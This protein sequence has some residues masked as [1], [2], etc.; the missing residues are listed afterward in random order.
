MRLPS[1]RLRSAVLVATALLPLFVAAHT[2]TDVRIPVQVQVASTPAAQIRQCEQAR[3]GLDGLGS[4]G[5]KLQGAL[6]VIANLDV[7]RRVWPKATAAIVEAAHLQADVA[8]EFNLPRNAVD[9]LAAALPAAKATTH[10]AWLEYRLGMAF[11]LSGQLTNAEEHYITAERNVQFARLERIERNDALQRIGQF[12]ARQNKPREAMKRFR[13]AAGLAGQR[14]AD[15]A[16][17]HLM[18][19][20]EAVRLQDDPDKFEARR[21]TKAVRAAIRDARADARTTGHPHEANVIAD[22]EQETDRLAGELD[23]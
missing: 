6:T 4:D 13:E 3:A 11:E 2:A 5:A 21:E 14:P 17:Y 23:L 15:R 20:R 12:Y 9:A 7:V 1:R 22:V 10:E 18:A 16:L 8:L 19:L